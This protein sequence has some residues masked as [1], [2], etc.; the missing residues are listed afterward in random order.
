MSR[1]SHALRHA[2]FTG[3]SALTAA[4]ASRLSSRRAGTAAAAPAIPAADAWGQPTA[5][6]RAS[7][8]YQLRLAGRARCPTKSEWLP[9][10]FRVPSLHVP[11]D[12]PALPPAH[13]APLRRRLP[14]S[15]GMPASGAGSGLGAGAVPGASAAAGRQAARGCGRPSIP[16]DPSHPA[17]STRSAS[18]TPYLSDGLS[19]G[20]SAPSRGVL[21]RLQAPSVPDG[22]PLLR[23]ASVYLQVPAWGGRCCLLWWAVADSCACLQPPQEPADL[24]ARYTVPTGCR[25][26][27]ARRRPVSAPLPRLP[28]RQPPLPLVQ[29]QPGGAGALQ[30]V[31]RAWGARGRALLSHGTGA[32]RRSGGCSVG[33]R[34]MRMCAQR[35]PALAWGQLT[36]TVHRRRPPAHAGP[37][38]LPQ[39]LP[40]RHQQRLPR[41]G[42]GGTVSGTHSRPQPPPRA[43]A[44]VG[45]ATVSCRRGCGLGCRQPPPEAA[46]QGTPQP[47]CVSEHAPPPPTD[48]ASTYPSLQGVPAR[49]RAL[50][51]GR[52]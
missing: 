17:R 43:S 7:A 3:L 26:R 32:W 29:R 23:S 27:R 39:Q 50:H 4:A 30:L 12:P 46:V 10:V 22:T 19:G 31:A 24:A 35:A 14:D 49:G 1:S 2:I 28:G 42:G 40:G 5:T 37:P 11:T 48:V 20:S 38:R 44:Y 33:W 8:V 34:A 9:A 41:L 25:P 36:L 51:R 16:R 45:A 52:A 6:P 13:L 47:P 15:D 21:W 18:G